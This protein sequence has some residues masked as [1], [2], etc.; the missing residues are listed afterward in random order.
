MPHFD[1]ALSAGSVIAVAEL[2]NLACY[3]GIAMDIE[4]GCRT[5]IWPNLERWGQRSTADSLAS[6]A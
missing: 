6:S 4:A 2:S 3:D 5:Q 1:Y